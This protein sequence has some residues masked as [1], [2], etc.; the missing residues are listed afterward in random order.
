M[1]VNSLINHSI[2]CGG[3]KVDQGNREKG[4]DVCAWQIDNNPRIYRLC[5]KSI[6][7]ISRRSRRFKTQIS[8]NLMR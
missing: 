6:F 1:K 3:K 5:E 7:F 4:R 2:K 8:Q